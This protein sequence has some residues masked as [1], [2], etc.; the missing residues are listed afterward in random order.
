MERSINYPTGSTD[1]ASTRRAFPRGTVGSAK[2]P[3]SRAWW[4]IWPTHRHDVHP[5]RRKL[6]DATP[7]EG[8]T[9]Q[10]MLVRHLAQARPFEVAWLFMLRTSE[11]A[12]SQVKALTLLQQAR[13]VYWSRVAVLMAALSL[14]IAV[15]AAVI[16]TR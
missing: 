9:A 14:P 1:P 2:Q 4:R 16:A 3:L 7:R 15:V 11:H 12:E 5:E 6:F 10:Q 13:T 8:D